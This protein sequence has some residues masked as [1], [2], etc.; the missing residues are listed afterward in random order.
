VWVAPAE[1]GIHVSSRAWRWQGLL[2]TVGASP[3]DDP[4]EAAAAF[5]FVL[6]PFRGVGYAEG[7]MRHL[8]WLAELP[9]AERDPWQPR[10]ELATGDAR[11][12]GIADG[13]AVMVES[14]FGRMAVRAQVHEGIRPGVLGL[15]LGGGVWPPASAAPHAVDLL[16][17]LTDHGTGQWRLF[18]TR[19]RVG[20]AG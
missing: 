9:S 5:P 12:L 16:G 15:P 20:R 7:G 19:A 3:A 4:A 13:D 2:E 17:S 10:V 11:E 18:S 8:P 14:R 1:Q 6:V